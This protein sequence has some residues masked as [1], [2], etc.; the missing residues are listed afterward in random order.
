MARPVPLLVALLAVACTGPPPEPP[1]EDCAADG[2]DVV[3]YNMLHGIRDEDPAAQPDDRFAERLA[4]VAPALGELRPDVILLQEF[5]IPADGS[6][7]PDPGQAI[8]DELGDGWWRLFGDVFGNPPTTGPD[9]GLG[10]AIFSCLLLE[11]ETNRTVGFARVAL[12]ARLAGPEGSIDV[13]NLHIDGGD[14]GGPQLEEAL[15][16]IEQTSAGELEILGGDLNSEAGEPAIEAL[17]GS[18]W[19]DLGEQAGLTCD[20]PGDVGCTGG[21]LPL[22]EP[23]RRADE[24][25]DYVWQRGGDPGAS[26]AWPLFD[27][28]FEL[29]DGGVLWGSDHHGVAA[30]VR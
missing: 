24:R 5:L 16:L 11:A 4:L 1:V 10:Q 20:E 12:H 29:P 15:A 19:T 2:V 9:S 17:D 7:R 21:A 22:G 25:I 28:P 13:Y 18:G 8:L 27:E 30:T 14:D 6:E 23:G 3:A 26:E